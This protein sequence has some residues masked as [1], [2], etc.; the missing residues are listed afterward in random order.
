[1]GAIVIRPGVS[2]SLAATVEQVTAAL[3]RGHRVLVFPECGRPQVT[4]QQPGNER[5]QFSRVAFQAAIDAAVVVSPVAISYRTA[6]ATSTAPDDVF[7]LLWRIL[8]AGPL[9]VRVTWLPVIPAISGPGHRSGHRDAAARRTEWAI[10]RAL[11]RGVATGPAP[12]AVV[13]PAPALA[14]AS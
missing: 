4:V 10:D 13:V 6:A 5:A 2:R 8:R 7:G 3:R 14:L 12:R 9:T 11:G 1:M